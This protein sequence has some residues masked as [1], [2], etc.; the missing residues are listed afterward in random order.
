[1]AN[2]NLA[3]LS[4]QIVVGL[5]VS[6]PA[7]WYVGKWRVGPEKAKFTDAIWISVLGIFINA[8]IGSFVGGGIGSLLQL[9]VNL[10]LIKN[11]FETD[12]VNSFIISIA[13]V[14]LVF[15]VFTILGVLGV[16]VLT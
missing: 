1:V 12:W 9:L 11:Y 14:V 5:I 13:A 15:V 6:A 3:S 8:V 10:Y 2:L 4:I 16:L 7:L